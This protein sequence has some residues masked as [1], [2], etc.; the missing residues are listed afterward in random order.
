MS[1]KL[2]EMRPVS[3][4]AGGRALGPAHPYRVRRYSYRSL[5]ETRP[6]YRR[7]GCGKAGEADHTVGT[8][9]IERRVTVV[10]ICICVGIRI[11]IRIRIGIRIGI[12]VLRIRVGITGDAGIVAHAGRMVGGPSLLFGVTHAKAIRDKIKPCIRRAAAFRSRTASSRNWLD[13]LVK[14]FD[15]SPRKRYRRSW[16]PRR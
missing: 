15:N 14:W 4:T 7:C 9:L 8:G 1:L 13:A 16:L 10:G 12:R 3:G 6:R 11:R 5:S 2:S